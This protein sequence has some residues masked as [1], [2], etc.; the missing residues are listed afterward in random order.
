MI[1]SK[2]VPATG[3]RKSIVDTAIAAGKFTQFVAGLKAAGL[4]DALSG[5]GPFTVFA[6][7]DKALNK[8]PAGTYDTLLKDPAKLREVLNYHVVAGS[9]MAKDVKAGEVMTLQGSAFT[10]SASPDVRANGSRLSQADIVATN[11][12]IHAIDQVMVPRHLQL[13]AVAA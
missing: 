8:L 6:P 10:A 7:T 4:I 2:S 12:V 5:K 9:I 13:R 3:P 11:G 1:H